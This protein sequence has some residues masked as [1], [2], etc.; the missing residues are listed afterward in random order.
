MT[1][2]AAELLDAVQLA[3]S[4]FGDAGLDAAEHVLIA[5]ERLTGGS[6]GCTGV[7]CWSLVLK[8]RRLVPTSPEQRVGAG[9]EVRF[10]VDLDA[11]TAVLAGYGD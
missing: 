8:P 2:T 10:T 9:G 4:R 3:E 11:G 7:R 6:P 1:G 5:A